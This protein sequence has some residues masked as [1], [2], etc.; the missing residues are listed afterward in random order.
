MQTDG[1]H[2]REGEG[3]RGRLTCQ[4]G[5][6][7]VP[8]GNLLN[9]GRGLSSNQSGGHLHGNMTL[10]LLTQG[11]CH[12]GGG[13]RWQFGRLEWVER[14]GRGRERGEE[15]RGGTEGEGSKGEE[16]R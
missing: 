9:K 4:T 8:T 11:D 15:T 3:G 6:E 5:S 1:W 2:E 12:F 16:E 10:T 13:Y 7:Q 14:G